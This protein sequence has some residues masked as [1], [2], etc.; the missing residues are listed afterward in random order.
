MLRLSDPVLAD[1]GSTTTV[2]V[3]VVGSVCVVRLNVDPDD[4]LLVST[5][6]SGFSSLTTTVLTVFAGVLKFELVAF[7]VIC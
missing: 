6:P 4:V 1:V 3:P 7:T 2:Y 5:V